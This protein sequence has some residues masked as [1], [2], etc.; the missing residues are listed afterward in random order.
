MSS[1]NQV[2]DSTV[3]TSFGTRKTFKESGKVKWK[4]KRN[5]N[6]KYDI[7]TAIVFIIV[8]VLSILLENY[9]KK[10]SIVLIFGLIF[11]LLYSI[12]SIPHDNIPMGTG[13]LPFFGHALNALRVFDYFFDAEVD[14]LNL[15]K[16]ETR[17]YYSASMP[18]GKNYVFIADPK[19]IDH[20]FR[21]QF[22]DASKGIFRYTYI[23][24]CKDIW[25]NTK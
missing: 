19:L 12:R 21:L 14:E 5:L 25:N 9:N 15:L 3:T 2:Q 20:I 11:T 22:S 4:T 16:N 13:Y 7:N 24:M 17:K 18:M 1:N 23:F 8:I 6:K 10:G